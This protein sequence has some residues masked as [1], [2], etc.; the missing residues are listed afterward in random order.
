MLDGIDSGDTQRVADGAVGRR[1]AS[2]H[3]DALLAAEAHDVPHDQEIAGEFELF[4]QRQLALDLPLCALPKV[5]FSAAVSL[6]R[7]FLGAL[8]QERHHGLAL[9]H[10]IARKFVTEIGAA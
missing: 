6:P 9:R 5:A 3:Q 7:A 4:D 8:A 2:L 10:G 1:A